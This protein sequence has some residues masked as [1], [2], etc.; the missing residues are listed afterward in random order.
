M[1]KKESWDSEWPKEHLEYVYYCPICEGGESELLLSNL[2]DNAFHVAPG[3]WNLYQC[4]HCKSAY[5]NPRPD[6]ASIHIAYGTYYTH[7]TS[8]K[9]KYLT[10]N[11]GLIQKL[12]RQLANGYY[13]YHHGTN[14]QPSMRL[15][16]WLLLCYPKFRKRANAQFRYLEKPRPDQKLLDVGCGNGDYLA[17]ASEA[18]WK[19]KGVEPDPK[20]VE[21]ARSR[22]L[23]VVQGGIGEVSTDREQFDVITMS[24]VIEHVH[25]PV[26]FVKQAYECLKPSGILY[27]DTPNIEGMGAKRYG[28]N[29]RGIESPRHLVLF[30]GLGLRTVLKKAGFKGLVYF[31]RK[32][33][34]RNIALK[35]YRIQKGLSPYN[36]TPSKMPFKDELRCYIPRSQDRE[37]FLTL[38]ASKG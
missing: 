29:W 15:G 34:R 14:R 30:S 16:A 35:S 4:Q 21:I 18:G 9:A 11:A 6:S 23:E 10:S 24:H 20:A 12:R 36:E 28:E 38:I 8:S 5:L 3:K 17:I 27:I 13:N 1:S 31:P 19:V 32:E 7:E 2:V 33:E 25:D 22:G 37:E 26:H